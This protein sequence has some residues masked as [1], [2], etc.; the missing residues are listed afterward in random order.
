MDNSNPGL[1]GRLRGRLAWARKFVQRDLWLHLP[2]QRGPRFLYRVLRMLVL[3]I[4]GFVKSDV[5]M[6]SAALTYQVIF[7]LVPL[8][9][10]MLAV[11]KGVGGFSSVGGEVQNFLLKNILPKIST[12]LAEG[13]P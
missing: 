13:F 11:V 3:I 5:F 9:V 10:V 12:A 2:E 7:A 4:E 8:L 6:L 1:I